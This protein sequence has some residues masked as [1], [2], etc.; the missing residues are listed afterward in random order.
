MPQ[1]SPFRDEFLN[2]KQQS[3]NE[4]LQSASPRRV[5]RN[6][7]NGMKIRQVERSKSTIEKQWCLP[8]QTPKS[9]AP[10]TAPNT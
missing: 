9:D 4:N 1:W 10:P 6:A 3:T 2:E 8:N 7:T 5:Q